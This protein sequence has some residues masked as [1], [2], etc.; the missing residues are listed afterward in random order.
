MD[1][2]HSMQVF[3]KVF[4][5]QNFSKVSQAMQMN[6]SSVSRIISRLEE[7]VNAPLFIRNTRKI[8]P[9]ELGE[10]FYHKV[11]HIL[12]MVEGVTEE[13]KSYQQKK[14]RVHIS[15]DVAHFFSFDVL[16]TMQEHNPDSD[17]EFSFD[18]EFP[19]IIQNNIDFSIALTSLKDSGLIAR[20]IL[21]GRLGL[22]KFG[23]NKDLIITPKAMSGKIS[24]T[25]T[26]MDGNTYDF[27][28]ML[29]VSDF[30]RVLMMAQE[31]GSY[32]ILPI[33]YKKV[34]ENCGF[35][36]VSEIEIGN[37]LGHNYG[38]YLVYTYNRYKKEHGKEIV[39]NLL[40]FFKSSFGENT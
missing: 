8:V 9:T 15:P 6:T 14:V 35:D 5:E 38:L 29:E 24:K 4:Q 1:L 13:L 3:S 27:K 40:T 37:M 21:D 28:Q 30:S 26:P 12:E 19:D 36:L 39:D 25:I 18:Q 34:C 7:E 16:R 32:C 10:Q 17:F 23:S 2:F 33:W 20:K 31:F 22:F 11:Q